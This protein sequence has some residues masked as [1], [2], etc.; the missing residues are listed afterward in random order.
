ME[1]VMSDTLE[2]KLFDASGAEVGTRPVGASI[3]GVRVRTGLIHEVIRW[4]RAK[5][6]AGTH[7]VK[8][9]AEAS[10]G[11][12]KPWRQKGLGKARSGSN[13]SPVWVGGGVAHGPKPRSYE[14]SLNKKLK[15]KVLCGALSSRVTE[16]KCY[17]LT[18]FG[19][20]EPKTR[21]AAATLGKIGL[22]GKKTLLVVGEADTAGVK[23]T[24]NI[25]RVKPLSASGVTTYDVVNSEY[26]LFTEAGLK[27]FESRMEG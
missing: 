18:E 8:T 9:R 20:T 10:G 7:K 16:G 24:R 6:R 19:L 11:G 26:V 13:T 4:Q 14:F 27:E 2:I 22:E 25:D 1:F 15:K 17:A 12:K 21:E 5:W 3:F 23:S